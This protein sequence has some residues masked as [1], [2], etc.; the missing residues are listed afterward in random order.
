M[1]R[2]EGA[3]EQISERLSAL[4]GDVQTVHTV[5]GRL[6]ET[7]RSEIAAGD[8][9]LR[10]EMTEMRRQMNAQFYWTL[11]LILGSILIPFLRELAR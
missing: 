8:T 9:A 4:R 6:S 1:A 3:Y 10:S 5:I 11:T 7:M 2:L